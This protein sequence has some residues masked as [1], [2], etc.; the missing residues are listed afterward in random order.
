MTLVRGETGEGRRLTNRTAAGMSGRKA[1]SG[2]GRVVPVLLVTLIVA[3]AAPAPASAAK[4]WHDGVMEPTYVTNCASIIFGNPYQ[5]I[6]TQSFV[7]F[8]ADENDLPE[9]GE[10]FYGHSIVAGLGNSCS[11]QRAVIEMTPPPGAALAIDENHPINCFYYKFADSNAQPGPA[12]CPARPTAG[13]QGAY[14]FPAPESVSGQDGASTW[15]VPQGW[16]VEIQ[17][18]LVATRQLRGI[19]ASPCDCLRGA[20]WILD[21]NSS[22]W[23]TPEQGIFTSRATVPQTTITAGPSG[24]TRQRRVTFR[25]RSSPAAGAGFEC[26]LDGKP[27]RDCASPRS[28]RVAIGRH[29]F[30]VRAK[31]FGAID[32]TPAVRHFRRIR[33]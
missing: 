3:L 8:L 29:R 9:P 11:G 13:Q 22:P 7:G 33:R 21:G 32:P 15:P 5:E 4:E 30:R 2:C 24:A 27:F 12:D 16:W 17:Y 6:G 26:S 25:F 31:R 28:Y 20:N 1:R 23:V 10:V 14:R 19:G 18:P